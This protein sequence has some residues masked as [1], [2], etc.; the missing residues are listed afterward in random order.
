MVEKPAIYKSSS[1][2][3]HIL[4]ILGLAPFNIDENDL[5]LKVGY[6]NFL[7]FSAHLVLW[8]KYS[9]DLLKNMNKFSSDSNSRV[10]DNL[11]KY[12]FVLQH[13]LI[14]PSMIYNFMKR[15]H[16]E[17]FLKSISKFDSTVDQLGWDFKVIHSKYPVLF[18]FLISTISMI[19]YN[20][21]VV[22]IMNVYADSKVESYEILISNFAYIFTTEFYFMISFQFISSCYCCYSRFQ[23]LLKN[24][25]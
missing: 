8:T 14:I 11:L 18:I 2:F 23:M 3:F 19:S 12:Q 24:M 15:K 7:M 21:V 16:V 25:K 5:K 17:Y 13:Y 6:Q 20:Y 10:M 9:W 4:K 1:F 22:V